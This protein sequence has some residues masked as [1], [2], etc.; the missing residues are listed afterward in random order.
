MKKIFTKTKKT[1]IIIV[2]NE[3]KTKNKIKEP[4]LCAIKAE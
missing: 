1:S 3:R 2:R 4:Y